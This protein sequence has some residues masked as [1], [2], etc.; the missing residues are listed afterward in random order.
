MSKIPKKEVIHIKGAR[1]HNLKNITLDIP[2]NKLV[3]ITGLSGSGKSSLAFDTIYAEAERRFVESL[4]SYA[5]QFLGIREKP[6]VDAIEGLSPAIAIDQRTISKNPR[7]TVGTITEIY[8]YLRILFA[9]LG[10]PHCPS[11]GRAVKKQTID[12]MISRILKLQKGSLAL[13]L[14]PVV[15][16]RKGE[17]KKILSEIQKKGFLRVRLD[18]GVMRTEEALDLD[19]DPKKRHSIDV[20]VDRILLEGLEKSRLRDSLE[21]VLSLTQGMVT[22]AQEGKPD[23]IFSENFSCSICSLSLPPIEPRL[24]SFNSPYGACA[25]CT[26]LGS[27]LEVDP[28]LIIP[29]KGLT[30][31]EGAIQPWAR[32]SHRVGRQSWYGWMLEDL[33]KE[34]K[35][36]LNEPVGKLPKKIIDIILHGQSSPEDKDAFEGVIP[37]LERRWK[38]TDS[39]WTRSEIERY[40]RIEVCPACRGQRLRREALSVFIGGKNISEIV[41]FS[42]EYAIDFMQRF[43]RVLESKREKAV[44]K[45]LLKEILRRFQFL[46]DVGLEYITLDRSSTT[47]SG[48]EAQRVRLATQIGSGLSGVIY[49]LDEPSIGLH[50]RDHSRLIQT[51]KNLRDLGNTV[52]V[53]EH[54]RDTMA[55]ADWIIDLGPGAGRHGGKVIFEGTYEQLQK[56]KTITGDYLADRKKVTISSKDRPWKPTKGG[57]SLKI[58]GAG[59]HNL[60]NI[61]VEIP[62]EKFVCVSGVSGSGKSTL[63]DDILARALYRHFYGSRESPGKHKAIEGIEHIDK[64]IVVDQS[65]IGRTPRSNPATY[66]GAFSIIRELFAQT[67]DAKARGYKAGRFSFNVKGGRC[68]E[69]EGQGVKKIEMHFLPDIYVECEECKGTRYN[70]EAL[71]INYNHE[72]IAQ[73]LDR[74]TE[75]ALEFF[76]NIPQVKSRLQTLVDVGLSYM[77]LGQPATTLSGGEAQRVKLATELARK[78]TGKTLYILDEPTTGLHFEDIRKLL[79]VLSALVEKG[80]TVLVIEHNPDVLKNADWIIDLGPGGGE[81]GGEVIA[82]GT[83]QEIASNKKSYTGKWL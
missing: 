81:K 61:D 3:V 32:A 37:N 25:S 73:V 78:T 60:K 58:K 15:R 59:E 13:I 42:I 12:E 55:N 62:L 7:S 20:V 83:P 24:F 33:A 28:E 48:G 41:K 72:N 39:D 71:A 80:N 53:V 64:V 26:G 74:T 22:V 19:I 10:E 54:D 9:R 43:E 51:L 5:R 27:R 47:L 50:P 70:P 67:R 38:E 40:M 4:S 29:N 57:P 35:F 16:D 52:L 45:P 56:A 76:K 68:E 8:D 30:L 17:H 11:C 14:A 69:C 65:S 79:G 77:K 75:D 82:V 1:A 49:V 6:D 46:M 36:S 23:N 18:G 63:V 2:K 34:H 44:S 21:T 31:A 66:T